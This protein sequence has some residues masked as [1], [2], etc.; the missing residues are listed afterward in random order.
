MIIMDT[1]KGKGCFFAEGIQNN[2]SMAFNLEK[3]K[4]AI[5]ALEAAAS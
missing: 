3:A 4:E 1:V 5:A 2:H